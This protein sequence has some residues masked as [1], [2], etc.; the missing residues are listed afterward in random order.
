MAMSG[1]RS[2]PGAFGRAVLLACLGAGGIVHAQD[3]EVDPGQPVE[4]ES[5]ELV[6]DGGLVTH[7]TGSEDSNGPLATLGCAE[8]RRW[9][10]AMIPIEPVKYIGFAPPTR[11]LLQ[12][13]RQD[14]LVPP[15]DAE[16]LHAAAPDPKSV[17]W[18]DAGHNLGTAASRA[19]SAWLHENLGML[20]PDF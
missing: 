19:R 13:G 4:T 15:R 3:E 9:L 10:D 6:G 2:G 14:A 20:A 5:P 17:Q 8:R 12:S 7:F 1:G 18:Y 11:L 16:R